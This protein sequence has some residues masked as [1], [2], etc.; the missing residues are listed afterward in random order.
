MKKQT[1][2]LS[3]SLCI[4]S[5]QLYAQQSDTTRYLKGKL[6]VIT[7]EKENGEG[8]EFT[9]ATMGAKKDAPRTRLETS[10]GSFDLGFN[11]YIDRTAYGTMNFA[12]MNS[13][14][15]FAF[16]NPAAQ[17]AD[18]ELRTGKSIHLNFGIVKQQ[19]SLYKHY[20]NIVYGL[21]YDINNWHYRNPISW[22]KEDASKLTSTGAPFANTNATTV[23]RD[24]VMY[25]KNKLVTN[26]LQVPVLIRFETS[27]QHPSRNVYISA[28]AYFGYLVRSHTKQIEDGSKNKRKTFD[29]FNLNKFQ[30]G[31]QFELG[32]EGFSIYLK[33]QMTTL[34]NYG[35]VQ[36]P[37]AFGFRL[38]GL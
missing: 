21:T 37:Y 15:N 10:W 16:M 3:L 13:I 8:K 9:K 2:I 4:L 36:Y 20:V 18:F 11:N 30:M 19:L 35:T 6:K 33:R 34:T 26:Y 31:A 12:D 1:F 22:R 14:D 24:T 23:T 17:A 25:T 38:T 7:T 27:P 29:D 5:L 32:Y 28:G